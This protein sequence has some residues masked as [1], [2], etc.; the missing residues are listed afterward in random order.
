MRSRHDA[1]ADESELALLAHKALP[2]VPEHAATRASWV[3]VDAGSTPADA[4]ET[5]A[6]PSTP[7]PQASPAAPHG[8]A[9][10]KASAEQV[11]PTSASVL[12][13]PNH[14]VQAFIRESLQALE[15]CE[16]YPLASSKSG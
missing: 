3:D 12:A 2:A 11:T 9:A 10:A 5:Q 4:A 13:I 14:V 6:E 7:H 8:P 1:S 16:R 15:N